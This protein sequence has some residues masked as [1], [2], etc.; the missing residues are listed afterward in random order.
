M[1]GA[2]NSPHPQSQNLSEGIGIPCGGFAFFR[3]PS[4]KSEKTPSAVFL[5]FD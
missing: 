4:G 5:L 1:A 3:Q 2:L